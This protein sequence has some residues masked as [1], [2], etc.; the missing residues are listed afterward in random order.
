MTALIESHT[1]NKDLSSLGARIS[2]SQAEEIKFMKRW[3][4]ARVQPGLDVA[5][6]ILATVV[7]AT[8]AA[9]LSWL[10]PPGSDLAAHVYQPFV[11][12]LVEVMGQG[13][14]GYFQF[15][16]DVSNHQ[17]MGFCGHQELHDTEPRFRPH[18]RE[19]IGEA[20]DL[21]RVNARHNSRIL[22]I[23][24]HVKVF[25]PPPPGILE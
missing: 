25:L 5:E 15:R 17:A 23:Q 13:R 8:V 1:E 6:A 19:H 7:A 24:K 12:Q 14:I 16:L 22:V 2:R 4:A 21:G 10:G 18:R 3:L 9:T 11:F 20:N